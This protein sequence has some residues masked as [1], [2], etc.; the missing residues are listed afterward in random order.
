MWQT[1]IAEFKY[2]K[3]VVIP[4]YLAAVLMLLLGRIWDLDGVYGLSAATTII[5]FVCI[6]IMAMRSDKEKRDRLYLRLPLTLK[7]TSATRLLF[8]I[9]FQG[10]LFF[11]WGIVFFTD[12]LGH[13]NQAIWTMMTTSAFVIMVIMFF[14]INHDLGYFNTPIY[15]IFYFTILILCFTGLIVSVISGN[16][17]AETI[18]F[19]NKHQKVFWDTIIYGVLCFGLVYFN[20]RLFMWRKSY[21]S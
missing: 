17:N 18:S 11:L 21:L 19:G 14:A 9:L 10:G 5:Y 15:R 12:H 4:A 6:P 7:Q 20:Y 1:L 3:G 2:N 16:V 8:M 13:D